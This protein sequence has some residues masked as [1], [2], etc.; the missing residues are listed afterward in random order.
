MFK[1]TIK[2]VALVVAFSSAVMPV[3]GL[4]QDSAE[5]AAPAPE[6]GARQ[7]LGYGVGAVAASVIYSPL[8]VTYAGL[9]L[10][11]GGLGYLLSAGRSDV[12]NNIIFPA[13]K[14]NYIITPNH[15]K[16]L[17]PVIFVGSPPPEIDPAQNA[18]ADN[19]SAVR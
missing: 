6:V 5:P 7:E 3:S 14:G 12:A 15:L 11:T 10:V 9:G 1:N 18:T 16:G 13:V 19:S 2:A 4:A 8:K 17:E